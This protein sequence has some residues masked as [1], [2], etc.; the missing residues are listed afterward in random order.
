MHA[1]VDVLWARIDPTFTA[2]YFAPMPFTTP[3]FGLFFLLVF[4]AWH[5]APRP[6][7]YWVLL[8]ASL[9]YCGLASPPS[10]FPLLVVV[11]GGYSAALWLD[12][13]T[14]PRPRRVILSSAI[15]VMALCLFGPKL[16]ESHAGGPAGPPGFSLGLL[17]VSFF[18]LKVVAYL[19]DVYRKRIPAERNLGL[20]AAYVALFLELPA[21]P[22]DRAQSVLPHLR[23]P[24]DFDEARA[25]HGLRLVL[26]GFFKKFVV[27]DRLAVFVAVAYDPPQSATGGAVVVATIAFAFQLFADFSAY[28]DMAVGFG[29]CLG[30]RLAQNFDSPYT[31]TTVSKFWTRWHISFSTWLRDYVFLP[32]HYRWARLLEGRSFLGFSGEHWSYAGAAAVTMAL[33]GLW[34]G[35]G[36]NYLLWGFAIAALM[37]TSVFTRKL[38]ARVAKRLGLRRVPRLHAAGQLLGTFFFICVTWVFFRSDGPGAALHIFAQ[39]FAGHTGFLGPLLPGAAPIDVLLALSCTAAML[40]IEALRGQSGRSA[41]LAGRPAWLRWGICAQV[42]ILTVLLRAQGGQPFLYAGF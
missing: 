35:I 6:F 34:H 31:A 36:V 13:L 33:A 7:R 23:D 22:I 28:S 25:A 39:A 1:G 27:A 11:V 26:W 18:T 21:G 9:A 20:F 5:L 19:V 4:V 17:G 8:V 15:V 42:I 12:R 24:P 37:V 41:L 3:S 14:S 40:A 10:L 38:R 29:H 30:L 2:Q 32:L 16:I